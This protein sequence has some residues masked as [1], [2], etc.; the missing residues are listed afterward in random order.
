MIQETPRTAPQ[1][2]TAV[3]AAERLGITRQRV[4]QLCKELNVGSRVG[5]QWVFMDSDIR[6]MERREKKRGPKPETSKT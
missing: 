4:T 2:L 5:N 3:E 1:M 6:L